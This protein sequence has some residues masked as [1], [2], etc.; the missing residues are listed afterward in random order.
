M[1]GASRSWEIFGDRELRVFRFK[2]GLRTHERTSFVLQA[3]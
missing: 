1:L 2:E 3:C